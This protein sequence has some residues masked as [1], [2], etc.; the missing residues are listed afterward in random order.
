MTEK[1][2]PVLKKP[3]VNHLLLWV[4]ELQLTLLIPYY[5]LTLFTRQYVRVSIVLAWG[6]LLHVHDRIMSLW[7]D[8][9]AYKTSLSQPLFLN[10]YRNLNRRKRSRFCLFLRFWYLIWK[11][12]ERMVFFA[13]F[14]FN[15]II[16]ITKNMIIILMKEKFEENRGMI[17]N[18]MAKRKRTKE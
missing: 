3:I 6:K 4:D 18:T 7:G 12:S 5:M 2:P 8:V 9:W 1:R 14:T 11:C 17:D 16:C 13:L 15:Y 10:H